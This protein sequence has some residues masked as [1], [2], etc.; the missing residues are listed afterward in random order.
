MPELRKDPIIGRWVII[1]TERAKRPNDFR[2]EEDAIA[3]NGP[4]PFCEGNEKLTPPEVD[5]DRIPGSDNDSPGW[6]T[7]TVPN[8]YPALE[9]TP[10]LNKQNRG[11]FERMEGVGQH[12][13]IIESPDHSRQLADL[14]ID[15]IKRVIA[16]YKR[17]SL[18]LGQDQRFKYVLIFKNYGLAAGASLEHSHTQL[19][20][21]PVVPRRVSGEI[22]GMRSY[23][24][25]NNSCVFCDII[26][27][28]RKEQA[29]QICENDDFYAFCPFASR[30]PF[31]MCIVPKKHQH[32]FTEI[33]EGQIDS[34][35]GILKDV[36]LRIKVLLNN[37]PY[38]FIIHTSPLNGETNELCHWHV[39]LMPKLTKI[40]GFEWGTGF[41]INS[42]PPELAGECLREVS[43]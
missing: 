3:G 40:A 17:R 39:E 26:V 20:S 43:V 25:E 36:L 13:V 32:S 9:N 21:L 28:E 12:E 42:T 18:A 11:I 23:F 14:S 38:N 30:S 31:E 15:E 24:K 7:R 33:S 35:A 5:A 2:L 41:Y 34:F 22:E 1:A 10:E 4:C 16:V 6:L 29:R 19:I 8:K 27:Q 37:P